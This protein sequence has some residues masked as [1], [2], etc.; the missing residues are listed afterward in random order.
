[1]HVT[2][3]RRTG[4]NRVRLYRTVQSCGAACVARHE[5]LPG[6]RDHTSLSSASAPLIFLSCFSEN[7]CEPDNVEMVSCRGGGRQR[8]CKKLKRKGSEE[9]D[10][11]LHPS[12]YFLRTVFD[13]SNQVVHQC[14]CYSL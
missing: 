11:T 10:P 14:A 3:A 6:V 13:H 12:T 2:S 4:V 8:L 7:L 5:H 9:G 1:M